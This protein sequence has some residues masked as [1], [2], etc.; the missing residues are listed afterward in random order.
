MKRIGKLLIVAGCLLFVGI[1]CMVSGMGI[2]LKQGMNTISLNVGDHNHYTEQEYCTGLDGIEVL[3]TELSSDDVQIQ[4]ADGDEF[5]IRYADDAS[6][7]TYSITKENGTLRICRQKN[8]HLFSGQLVLPL[9]GEDDDMVQYGEVVILVPKEYAGDYDIGFT[10]GNVIMEDMKLAGELSFDM[11]S[12][13]LKLKNISSEKDIQADITSGYVEFEAVD[14][15]KNISIGMSSG[16]LDFSQVTA[17]GELNLEAGSGNIDMDTVA[18][19]TLQVSLT[20]GDADIEELTTEEGL[21]VIITS[22]N[23]GVELTDAMENYRIHTEMISGNCNLPEVYE[24]GEK[25]ISVDI[26]SGCV[27]VTFQE[28]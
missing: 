5:V 12:G 9:F 14:S 11:T 1:V 16:S 22:G 23:V 3:E 2:L 26:K 21:A 24:Q 13:S 20:S 15:E 6:N 27:W 17:Q 28:E 19:N 8:A 10:S 25:E 7:P 18:V 4:Y